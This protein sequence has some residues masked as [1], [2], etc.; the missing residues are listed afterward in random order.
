ML[1]DYK[2]RA[3][4]KVNFNL[5]VCPKRSDGFHDIES[6]FQ[7][8]SLYDEL[9]V[10]RAE[11]KGCKLFCDDLVLP[12]KNTLT[13]A[14]QA[15][16]EVTNCNLGVKVHLKKGI[17]AG[18]GLGGGSSDAAAFIKAL[19]KLSGINLSDEQKHAIAAKTGS[20]V[21]FFMHCDD[22]GSACSLVSGRGEKIKSIVP[23]KDLFVL[24]IFPEVSSSTKEAYS[25]VD[26]MLAKGDDLQYPSFCELEEIYRSSPKK[27]NFTNTFTPVLCKRYDVIWTALSVLRRSSAEYAEMSGSGSTVFGVFTDKQTAISCYS[28]LNETWKCELVQTI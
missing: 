27:W 14:Y 11:Q 25:L 21:F 17:P 1:E 10:S 5:K 2:I 9:V 4:A 24:L 8:I 16:I 18:G 15:F 23:R 6:I 26:E 7:T 12:E 22:K 19:E 20:D 13:L 28:M 3:Y